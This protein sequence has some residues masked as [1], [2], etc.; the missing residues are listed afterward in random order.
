MCDAAEENVGTF[1]STQNYGN[2]GWYIKWNGP[3][4]FGQIGIFGTTFEGGPLISV[5]RTEMSPVPLFRILL[6][7]TITKRAVAWVGSV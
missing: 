1:H 4:Q 7:K 5:G 6:T 3:F 2:F